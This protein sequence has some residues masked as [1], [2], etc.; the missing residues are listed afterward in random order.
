MA[1][2]KEE[3][4][5]TAMAPITPAAPPAYIPPVEAGAEMEGF[6]NAAGTAMYS[7]L[8]LAQPA[9]KAAAGG[10]VPIGALYDSLTDEVI[11]GKDDEID[12]V[13]AYHYMSWIQ[14][15]AKMGD[16]IE[17]ASTDPAS[18]L[19]ITARKGTT[20][21]GSRKPLVTEY[22]NFIVL[23]PDILDGEGRPRAFILSCSKTSYKIG[24][25]LLMLARMKNR[26]LYAGIYGLSILKRERDG[27]TWFELDIT[28]SKTNG[29][30]APEPIFLAAKEG[31]ATFKAQAAEIQKAAEKALEKDNTEGGDDAVLPNTD[32][33][34]NAKY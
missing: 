5:V 12:I 8:R 28:N 25:K 27:N 24:K 11:V 10:T 34:G 19:A 21:E 14:W 20:R 2:R 18:A 23:T 15:A 26:P 22:H 3:T 16:G 4:T 32:G 9:S 29:G 7:M 33:A 13:P 1:K 17:A 31:Y 30:F 6:E